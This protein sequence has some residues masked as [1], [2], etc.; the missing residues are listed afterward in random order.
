MTRLTKLLSLFAIATLAGGCKSGGASGENLSSADA[1]KSMRGGNGTSSQYRISENRTR[2]NYRVNTGSTETTAPRNTAPSLRPQISQT[3]ATVPKT[4]IVRAEPSP[5]QVRVVPAPGVKPPPAPQ[6]DPAKVSGEAKLSWA[7]P[8]RRENGERLARSELGRYEVYYTSDLGKSDTF[9][10][11]NTSQTS[12]TVANL[13]QD[14]YYFAMVAVDTDGVFSELSNE[15]LK[16]I[17]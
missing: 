2:T 10:I 6:P 16:I 13:E 12:L 11:E 7:I 8:T 9:R 15:V 14:T 1:E 5:K 17:R 3:L 4:A